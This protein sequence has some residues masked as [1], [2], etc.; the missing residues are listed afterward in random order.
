M[1]YTLSSQKLS[2]IRKTETGWEVRCKAFIDNQDISKMIDNVKYSGAVL[3]KDHDHYTGEY[4][5]ALC[6]DC[7]TKEGKIT[8]F[9]PLFFHNLSGYY[10]HFTIPELAK[11]QSKHIKLDNI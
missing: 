8:K 6:P 11:R 5:G 9:F 3:I 1:T 2:H 10:G 4:R 7:N